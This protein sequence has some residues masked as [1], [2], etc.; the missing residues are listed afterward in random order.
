MVETQT[1]IPMK[2]KNKIES[3]SKK[4]WS[5][6]RCAFALFVNNFHPSIYNAACMSSFSLGSWI[7]PIFFSRLWRQ[8]V[9]LYPFN[10]RKL[11]RSHSYL[12]KKPEGVA[13]CEGMVSLIPTLTPGI[14]ECY[15]ITPQFQWR[16]QESKCTVKLAFGK[17]S[18]DFKLWKQALRLET[19]LKVPTQQTPNLHLIGHVHITFIDFSHAHAEVL[20][21]ITGLQYTVVPNP[22]L[23]PYL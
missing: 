14:L 21:T 23:L 7:L 15:R 3:K 17:V 11:L 16:T 2:A 6:K 4:E 18:V 9:F 20:L 1:K 5:W 8:G 12:E 22:T 13:A 19:M 10:K